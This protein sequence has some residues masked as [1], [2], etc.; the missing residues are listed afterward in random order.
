MRTSSLFP[1]LAVLA[2][3]ILAGCGG[4]TPIEKSFNKA[5][6]M[7]SDGNY[8]A[9]IDEYQNAIAEDENDL[10]AYFNLGMAYE[11]LAEEKGKAGE[12][13]E[14]ASLKAIFASLQSDIFHRASTEASFG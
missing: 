4:Y 14:E 9:A 10:R 3:A 12:L 1:C 8:Q 6:Y 7:Y 11:A 13:E 5:A 2:V